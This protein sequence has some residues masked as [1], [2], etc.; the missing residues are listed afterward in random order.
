MGVVIDCLIGLDAVLVVVEDVAV[1][2]QL[3][4]TDS[5]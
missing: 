4:R 5:T 3:A 2:G 1:Y